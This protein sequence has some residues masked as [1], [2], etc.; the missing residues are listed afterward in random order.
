MSSQAALA[1][2]FA[3]SGAHWLDSSTVWRATKSNRPITR[4]EQ[5]AA[6]LQEAVQAAADRQSCHPARSSCPN[7]HPNNLAS[8]KTAPVAIL[9]HNLVA[10]HH[11]RP[12]LTNTR[13]NHSATAAQRW[14]LKS[15]SSKWRLHYQLNRRNRSIEAPWSLWNR[16]EVPLHMAAIINNIYSTEH[17]LNGQ[18]QIL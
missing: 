4:Q 1:A 17:L 5:V 13:A 18:V 11:Q 10:R 15:N 14:R 16:E 2:R 6:V 12:H 9:Y 7:T 3:W 8:S